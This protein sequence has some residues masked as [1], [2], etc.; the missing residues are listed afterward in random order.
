MDGRVYAHKPHGD[1]FQWAPGP[2]RPNGDKNVSSTRRPWPYGDFATALRGAPIWTQPFSL[3]VCF[4]PVFFLVLLLVFFV[5][6]P[7][8]AMRPADAFL[9]F[10]LC[11]E[12]NVAFLFG[13]F[14]VHPLGDIVGAGVLRHRT[15]TQF[16][17]PF[18]LRGFFL[19]DGLLF[20]QVF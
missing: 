4:F 2:D 19:D 16:R 17:R 18:F 1:D 7:S 3:Y 5:A 12:S 15:H 6:P 20:S 9:P 8:L 14:C 13:R 11:A 10:F